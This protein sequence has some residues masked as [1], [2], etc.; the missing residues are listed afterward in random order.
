MNRPLSGFRAWLIQRMTAVYLLAFIA[1]ILAH[2]LFDSPHSYPDWRT[3]V[4]RPVMSLA[5]WLFFVALA[6]HAWIG[7]RDVVLDYLK[8][9]PLRVGV[10]AL[11]A[12]ALLAIPAWA[13]LVLLSARA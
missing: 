10:L 1:F 3:W 12:G 9:V 8:P 6:M 11:L 13:S 2:F 7:L 5:C 4:A